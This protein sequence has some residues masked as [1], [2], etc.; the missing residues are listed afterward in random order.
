MNNLEQN[1][2][3]VL[4][5]GLFSFFILVFFTTNIY[6]DLQANLDLN[7]DKKTKLEELNKTLEKLN[8]LQASLKNENN[9]EAKDIKRFTKTFSENEI[10]SYINDYIEELNKT[11]W[12]AIIAFNSI[13]FSEPKKTEL[14]FKEVKIDLK[15]TI[16]DSYILNNVLDYLVSKDNK[17]SFFIKDFSFPIEKSWPYKI[18]LPLIMYIK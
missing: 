1:K 8:K 13:S 14:W 18:N 12:Q 10:I 9:K 3:K 4:L 5:I 16:K 15:L 6:T 17:Y 7:N 2:F 11:E